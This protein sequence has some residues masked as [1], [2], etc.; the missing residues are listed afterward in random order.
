MATLITGLLSLRRDPR[1][2]K[3]PPYLSAL[4]VVVG[5]GWLLILPL[6]DYSR[7]TY[8]SENALLPGQVHTYFG[9]SEHNVFRAYRQEVAGLADVD[10]DKR[11][12]GLLNILTSQGLKTSTQGYH[13]SRAGEWRNGTNVYGIIQAPRADATEAMVMIAAWRNA[14]NKI[15]YSGVALVLTLARYFKR[16]SLWSKDIIVLITPD[17]T[18]GPQAW[19]DAYHESH[20]PTAVSP[21]SIKSGALQGAVAV[22]YPANVWGHR[23]DKLH[24]VYDGINGQL[25]NLD[26]INTAI[27]IANNQ[28]GIGCTIQR[29]WNHLDSYQERLLTILRGML[30]QAVGHSSG[31][32]SSFIPYHIDAITLQTVGDGW[33]DE[34]S[35]GRAV[36]GLFRSINNLLEHFHQSF[37]FYLLMQSHRFVSIGT[38]LPSAMLIAGNF[39]VTAILLWF[40]SGRPAL[41]SSTTKPAPSA[42][43]EKQLI[44]IIKA[45]GG[46][47]AIPTQELQ[48]AERDLM[49]PLIV[50][51]SAHTA[52]LVPL[53]VLANTP[54]AT[55][56]SL[57]ATITAASAL[58]PVVTAV[59]VARTTK[60]SQQQIMVIQCFSL[61][62]LGAALSTLA[63]INFA[64]AF[65]VGI[66]AAPLSFVRPI[67]PG[68]SPSIRKVLTPLAMIL[69][70]AL[71]PMALIWGASY[72]WTVPL[73]DVLS[74]AAWAW[75]AEGVW[76]GV[77][78]WLVWWPA[79]A[80]GVFA[81][82]TGALQQATK[83]A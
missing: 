60:V 15:N 31:P 83:T 71:T 5:I 39:T 10:E 24:I 28:I 59:V 26:L 46:V 82:T 40:L 77:T 68:V 14:D 33:H 8:I 55:L 25:P 4:L 51:F 41:K 11:S 19:V 53:Y 43:D 27:N 29:M 9:G 21:L 62:V 80:C 37:F 52:G 70:A 47:A 7:R 30:S 34:I 65:F 2:I 1:L 45:Q 18:F 49:L 72:Y 42:L 73:R 32:H 36:E 57:G 20:D 75:R 23:F 56:E 66:S 69:F 58:L 78:V 81:L 61:L 35:L 79:W 67:S 17:S 3:L 44:T 22:D 76:T 6:N 48:I 50:V 63:T 74:A 54:Y 64:Q 12:E 13:F 38:Y 16:W